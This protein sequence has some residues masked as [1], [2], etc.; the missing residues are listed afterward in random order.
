MIA[1]NIENWRLINGY[2]NYEISSHGRCRNNKTCRILKPGNSNKGYY[3]VI[4]RKDKTSKTYSIHRLVADAFLENPLNKKCVD[5]IDNNPKN[6]MLC[7]LRWA[8]YN[9]NNRNCTKRKNTT[10]IYKGVTYFKKNQKWCAHIKI[11]GKLQHIGYFKNE[12]DAGRAYDEKALQLFGEYAK[13]N[14]N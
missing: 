14:F 4:L 2:D 12:E 1:N 3:I 9:E 5:H 13:L 7:N 8:T 6:N 11:N 10:S